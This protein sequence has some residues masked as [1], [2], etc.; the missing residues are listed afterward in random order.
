M[1]SEPTK[2]ETSV[3][4]CLFSFAHIQKGG[5]Y[6]CLF[7][8]GV[9]KGSTRFLFV[10]VRFS[11]GTVPMGDIHRRTEVYYEKLAQLMVEAEMPQDLQG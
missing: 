1:V 6:T 5:Y 10:L 7:P 9:H 4:V 2:N 3:Y 8:P 11:R